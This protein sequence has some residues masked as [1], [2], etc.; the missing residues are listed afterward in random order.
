MP[1][2]PHIPDEFYIPAPPSHATSSSTETLPHHIIFIPGNPGCIAYYQTFLA[3]LHDTL[4]AASSSPTARY[5]VY[6]RSLR[7]FELNDASNHSSLSTRFKQGPWGLQAEIAFVEALI[8]T[9]VTKLAR[10]S[11]DV[12][13][14]KLILVGHSLGT[15]VIMEVLR[16]RN[17]R[18]KLL[19][20]G[21]WS[22]DAQ[23]E[24]VAAVQLFPT[25]VD[26]VASPNGQLFG[27]LLPLPYA[28][29][30][31]SFFASCV[32]SFVRLFGHSVFDSLVKWWTNMPD[33]AASVTATWLRRK[34]GVYQSLYLAADEMTEMTAD[35]WDADIWGSA[36]SPDTSRAR[37]K[38]F[39]YFATKDSW[40][41]DKTR[42]ELIAT[43]GRRI[44]DAGV[45][46][47]DE[48]KPSMEID[49]GVV[50]HGFC[51]RMLWRRCFGIMESS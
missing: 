15:F 51:I 2:S 36:E 3:T 34:N 32:L 33:D 28:V 21:E 11:P 17:V 39:F 42:D 1:P 41:A 50:P 26:I 46:Q 31:L 27:W 35:R 23:F 43:R 49:K 44:A 12:T 20:K 9:Y 8:Q 47:E 10:P 4:N 14:P 29:T 30:V 40:I 38:L 7:G 24:I 6:G 48:W 19:R 25:V 37:T 18:A 22:A 45:E 13:K 16:R 5:A